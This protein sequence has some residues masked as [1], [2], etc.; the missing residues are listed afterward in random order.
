MRHAHPRRATSP[1]RIV[2]PRA[3]IISQ[4][5]NARA[6]T[7]ARACRVCYVVRCPDISR[8]PIS[9]V[10]NSGAMR[11]VRKARSLTVERFHALL[12]ELHEPLATMALLS[13]HRHL[14]RRCTGCCNGSWLRSS[15]GSSWSRYDGNCGFAEVIVLVVAEFLSPVAAPTIELDQALQ[16]IVSI[17]HRSRCIGIAGLGPAHIEAVHARELS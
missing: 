3:C 6:L 4:V 17:P 8:N 5:Q 9:L 16:I 1:G 10:H 15:Q 12:K 11:K 2:A 13:L 14:S 7:D